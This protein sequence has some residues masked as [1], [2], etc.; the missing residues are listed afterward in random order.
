MKRIQL[1]DNIVPQP[2]PETDALLFKRILFIESNRQIL[3]TVRDALDLKFFDV[4][5]AMDGPAA[6]KMLLSSNY[7]LILC[8]VTHPS[9]PSQMFF[10]AVRRIRPELCKSFI[11]ITDAIHLSPPGTMRVWKPIDM[12]ILLSAI[13]SVLKKK[14]RTS[15]EAI[16][17]LAA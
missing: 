15:E 7:D 8:D 6:I 3:D 17:E 10:E 11:A 16:P 14:F 13:E 1:D 5:V 9:F 4:T 12:H 2:A